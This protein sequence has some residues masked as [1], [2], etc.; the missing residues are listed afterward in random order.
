[1]S[2]S[3]LPAQVCPNCGH[4][5]TRCAGTIGHRPVWRCSQCFR[6]FWPKQRASWIIRAIQ[7]LLRVGAA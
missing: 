7:N 6:T 5:H 1:M 2:E 4:A 3:I